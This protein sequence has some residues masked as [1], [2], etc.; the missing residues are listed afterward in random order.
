MK[1]NK[2]LGGTTV[3]FAVVGLLTF[4][5]LFAIIEVGR[6]LFVWNA[7]TEATRRGARI[8]AVCPVN[9]PAIAQVT[10]FDTPDGALSNSPIVF[11]LKTS[12]VNVRYLN[13]AGAVSAAPFGCF[14]LD[15]D[16]TDCISFVEVSIDYSHTFLIPLP[17]P[18]TTITAPKFTTTLPVESLGLV[19]T[20]P[21]EAPIAAQC[22]PL[23][24]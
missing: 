5:I 16:F 9:D 23:P 21:G 6:G 12:D 18:V 14:E 15:L 3:E 11:G 17:L 7:L 8:A 13:A 10:I 2:Q 24:A 1:I 22:P 20:Y 4:G 19:P